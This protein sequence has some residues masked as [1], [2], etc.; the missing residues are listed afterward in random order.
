MKKI[1]IAVLA[2]IL[3]LSMAA[4]GRKQDNTPTTMPTTQPTEMTIL[5]NIDPTLDT[6]IPDPNINTEIPTYTDGTDP[7]GDMR[8][9]MMN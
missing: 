1:S 7:S 4:C 9:G 2:A 8:S 3:V 5:P 6:N